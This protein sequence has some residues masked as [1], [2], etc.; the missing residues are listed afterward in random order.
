MEGMT[1]NTFKEITLNSLT[2]ILN[3][4]VGVSSFGEVM[5]MPT[6]TKYIF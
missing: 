6:F 5:H 1:G 4:V 3:A 2:S